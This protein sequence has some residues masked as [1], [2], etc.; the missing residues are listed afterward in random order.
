MINDVSFA[1]HANTDE[2]AEELDTSDPVAERPLEVPPPYSGAP[3]G[4]TGAT[5]RSMTRRR[6]HANLSLCGSGGSSETP[7]TTQLVPLVPV[8][9]EHPA[10]AAYVV[11]AMGAPDLASQY[12][13]PTTYHEAVTG[14]Q[15][16]R[17]RTAIKAELTSMRKHEVF[18]VLPR[19]DMPT[20]SR[21]IK[22]KWVFRI[23][24]TSQGTVAKFKA[25]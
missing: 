1:N 19:T 8:E 21:A 4:A 23:K 6:A 2:P 12:D 10:F 16:K 14:P 20:S 25:G 13:T 15:A 17:W 24:Q 9:P 5:T 18:K 7:T 22:M 11:H 3:T